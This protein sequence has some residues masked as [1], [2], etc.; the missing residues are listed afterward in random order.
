MNLPGRLALTLGPASPP[1]PLRLCP[2]AQRENVGTFDSGI[3]AAE[4]SPDEELVAIVTGASAS[5]L[6][7]FLASP[8][9]CSGPL[10]DSSSTSFSPAPP[11]PPP[12]SAHTGDFQ[13][14][15]LT[16]TF[17]PLSEAP[18][19][20]ASFG[21]D[22]PVSVGWGTRTTQFHGSMGKT[23]AAAAAQADPLAVPW[24][25]SHADDGRVRIRWRGD[26]AW[27]A[28]SSVETT[29]DDLDT[30]GPGAR[31]RELRRIRIVSR[32]G[33]LSS[34]SEPVPGLEGAL[35][36]MPSGEL[37]AATQRRVV[38][39]ASGREDVRVVLFERNGLR[40]GE[41]DVR[42]GEGA[43]R[44]RVREL[45]W[46]AGSDVLGVWVEREDEQGVVEHV[47]AFPSLFKLSFSVLHPP[48]SSSACRRVEHA[49]IS[50]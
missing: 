35:A 30:G 28:V 1:H 31:A 4:W 24:L 48:R 44:A 13:L 5:C 9:A 49:R 10:A 11:A 25:R 41:F 16:R 8:C 38:D 42:E 3:A 50:R 32:V 39:A 33:E 12:R 15:L 6:R 17:D 19:H 37:I 20:T 46:S 26:G 23:A 21:A 29:P 45:E 34:T 27:L 2:T 18:L 40:R 22:A 36:W 7:L 43:R 14:L 47:G